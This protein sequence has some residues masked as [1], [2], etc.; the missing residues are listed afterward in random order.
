MFL[1]DDSRVF[2]CRAYDSGKLAPGPGHILAS[3]NKVYHPM[4][5]AGIA[6]P[7]EV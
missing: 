7:R 5:Q 4:V 6:I 3:V 2:T 1:L